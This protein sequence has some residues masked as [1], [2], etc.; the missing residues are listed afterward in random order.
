[1]IFYSMP[2]LTN[3]VEEEWIPIATFQATWPESLL[4]AEHRSSTWS[5]TNLN[6]YHQLCEQKR[7]E[8]T[9]ADVT[10]RED[11]DFPAVYAPS[12]GEGGSTNVQQKIRL[13]NLMPSGSDELRF[14]RQLRDEGRTQHGNLVLVTSLLE[15]VPNLGGKSR[16]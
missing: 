3:L 13:E 8:R 1:M 4:H 15:K 7:L 6:D 10:E 5:V 14:Y 16:W 11:S 12:D 9:T 2:I